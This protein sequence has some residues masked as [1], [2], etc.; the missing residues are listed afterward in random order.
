MSTKK[1]TIVIL[2]A[3]DDAEDRMLV[4][5]ALEESRLKNSINFVENGE[6]LMDYLHHRGKYAD[7]NEY[8]TPGLILLDLNMPKKD[9]REA[10][11]EIK[12]DDRL[13]LIPVVVLTTSKAEED[14]LR[15]YDL[16]VSSFITKPVT[17]TSLVDVMKTLSKYWFEIVE[18]PKL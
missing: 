14:I 1:N 18:L 3:D 10:L 13:K 16:G 5:D 17:F 11:K 9:G 15:T 12:S 8:P 6:E 2:I 7:L 4:K